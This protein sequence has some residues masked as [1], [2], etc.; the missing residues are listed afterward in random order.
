[1]MI[2]THPNTKNPVPQRRDGIW[3]F[4][5]VLVTLESGNSESRE[6]LDTKDGFD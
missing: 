1:M 4:K 5:D 2:I 3:V 6:Q